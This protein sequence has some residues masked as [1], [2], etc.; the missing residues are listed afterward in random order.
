MMA[1]IAG[2]LSWSVRKNGI[3]LICTFLFPIDP[4]GMIVEQCVVSETSRRRRI[5]KS[6]RPG[7]PKIE[8]VKSDVTRIIHRISKVLL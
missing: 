1:R 2:F 7:V 8:V 6:N 5:Y 4:I 3:M